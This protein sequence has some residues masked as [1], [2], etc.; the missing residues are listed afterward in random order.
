MCESKI[1]DLTEGV[2][3]LVARDVV[4]L[5]VKDNGILYVDVKGCKN[6][7]KDYRI[8]HIDFINHKVYVV[9]VKL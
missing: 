7:L 8:S 4:Y 6:L 9:R 2:E 5:E 1:I 3:R